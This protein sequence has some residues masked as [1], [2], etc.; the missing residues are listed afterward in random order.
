[1][2]SARP[3][4][5]KELAVFI[6]K[7]N[8]SSLLLYMASAS[9]PQIK[10]RTERKAKAGRGGHGGKRPRA[11]RPTKRTPTVEE[12]LLEAITLGLSLS[13]A[14]ALVGVTSETF[15][16]WR[17]KD[18]ELAQRVEQARAK[19][20]ECALRE[21][22]S[23]KKEGDSRAI[24]WFLEKMDRSA[25][26]NQSAIVG[27]QQNNFFESEFRMLRARQLAD[28]PM[29]RTERLPDGREGI[30]MGD[31]Q[32]PMLELE[33]LELDSDEPYVALAKEPSEET[34]AKSSPPPPISTGWNNGS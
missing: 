12:A 33:P 3:R 24:C 9:A 18:Q 27:A 22:H 21:L 14:S 20:I 13:R 8:L 6:D 7:S 25:Y 26:G 16:E 11:G 10:R 4:K 17:E 23:L 2:L 1:L 30:F 15:A 28:G 5:E 19:G 32:T 34:I 31:S 29:F